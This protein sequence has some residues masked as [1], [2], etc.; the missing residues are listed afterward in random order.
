MPHDWD[1]PHAHR[2]P[3]RCAEAARPTGR[4]LVVE[5]VRDRTATPES[6]LA[7]QVLLGGRER[8]VDEFRALA[9]PHGRTLAAV[10]E[11]SDHRTLLEFAFAESPVVGP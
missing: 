4:V 2:I 5:P 7:M 8:T 3:A 10:T 1:D 11:V 6:S 9:R